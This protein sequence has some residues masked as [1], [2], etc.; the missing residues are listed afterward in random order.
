MDRSIRGSFCQPYMVA[1]S[2]YLGGGDRYRRLAHICLEATYRRTFYKLFDYIWS[3]RREE[4]CG[5]R[6]GG[7]GWGL[8]LKHRKVLNEEGT[9]GPYDS[10]MWVTKPRKQKAESR[11]QTNRRERQK[12]RETERQK[13]LELGMLSRQLIGRAAASAAAA[14]SLWRPRSSHIRCS[15][16]AP[17]CLTAVLA[18]RHRP[19]ASRS[20]A[21]GYLVELLNTEI[22]QEHRQ[23][24]LPPQ[25]ISNEDKVSCPSPPIFEL[26][27]S[28][29]G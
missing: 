3:A 27:E 8:S 9:H 14:S 24:R 2:K 26:L 28:E 18:W 6:W 22:E 4:I 29:R 7:V 25:A 16:S 11:K 20:A 21:D 23:H 1:T 15:P 10:W 5:S 19:F 17:G 12:D 13:V